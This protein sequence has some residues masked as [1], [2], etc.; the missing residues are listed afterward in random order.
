MRMRGP[1]NGMIDLTMYYNLDRC[2]EDVFVCFHD[3]VYM[4]LLCRGVLCGGGGCCYDISF[5]LKMNHEEYEFPCLRYC[6]PALLCCDDR[7][8]NSRK[9]L[10]YPLDFLSQSNNDTMRSRLIHR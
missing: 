5:T 1:I 3:L 9:C 4:F 8:Y 6:L 2:S 10:L 7:H